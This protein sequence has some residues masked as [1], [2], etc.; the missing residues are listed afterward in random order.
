MAKGAPL[1]D[2]YLDEPDYTPSDVFYLKAFWDLHTC[3][4]MGFG[5]GPIP[6][7]HIVAYSEFAQLDCSNAHAFVDIMRQMDAAYLNWVDEKQEKEQKRASKGGSSKP[8]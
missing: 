5:P 6:W 2:W 8:N 1:P 7:N 4:S 3:R